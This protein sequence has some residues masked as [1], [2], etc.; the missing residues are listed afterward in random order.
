MIR[1]KALLPFALAA[2]LA[3]CGGGTEPTAVTS[4]TT[5]AS[6]TEEVSPTTE[7]SPTGEVSPEAGKVAIITVAVFEVMDVDQN[8]EVTE[9]E[10]VTY[11]T[12]KADPKLTKEE[13][14]KQFEA[15][16]KEGKIT[17][18]MAQ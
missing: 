6:P 16:A 5:E 2:L 11:Y 17:K 4:P 12:E 15:Q 9:E 3:S 10:Y 13:A 1:L 18:D 8:G 14:M 7:E